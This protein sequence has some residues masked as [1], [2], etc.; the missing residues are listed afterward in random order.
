LSKTARER[1]EYCPVVGCGLYCKPD[2]Y[3]CFH[4]WISIHPR[5]RKE[6]REKLPINKFERERLITIDEEARALWE[7]LPAKFGTNPYAR[8]TFLG[9]NPFPPKNNGKGPPRRPVTFKAQDWS[10]PE[11]L[12]RAK[13]K[14][15]SPTGS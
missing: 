8:E 7:S 12:T 3:F 15:N 6:V 9:V 1:T 14:C 5:Y 4:H 2:A 11:V 10:I 13:A